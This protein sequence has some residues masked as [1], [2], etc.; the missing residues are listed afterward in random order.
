VCPVWCNHISS[1]DHAKDEQAAAFYAHFNFR[2]S[3]TDPQHLFLLM[4]D[5]LRMIL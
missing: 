4:K 1:A 5:I 3:P 2:A